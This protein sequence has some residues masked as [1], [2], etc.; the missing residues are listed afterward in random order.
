MDLLTA[1]RDALQP[2]PIHGELIRIVE[3]QEHVATNNLVDNFAEQ[4][5][6][7]SLIEQTK[8]HARDNGAVLHYLLATPF[9]YPP[10]PWGSRF[11]SRFEPGIFYGSQQLPT[12]LAE[13]AFY[14]F[15][16][17]FGMSMPPASGKFL[18][19]HSVFSV[20]YRSRKG[21]QLHKPPFADH[22][23]QL[24]NPADYHVTQAVG[25]AMR[26]AGIEAFEYVSARDP[27]RGLNGA[28][29]SPRALATRE[30]CFQ[31]LWLCDTTAEQVSFYASADSQSWYFPLDMFLHDGHFPKPAL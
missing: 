19:Q 14:R 2:C 10:L 5:L 26:E 18:T 16:F 31:Q 22:E 30:P 15:V 20:R 25:A 17:W 24:R 12:A 4:E 8:P 27:D 9:R 23:Q 29:F 7:E 21:L 11:G 28:L 1:C 13:T 3:S 6:L